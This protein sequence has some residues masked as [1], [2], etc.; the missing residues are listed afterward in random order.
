MNWTQKMLLMGATETITSPAEAAVLDSLIFHADRQTAVS[1]P[2]PKLIAAEARISVDYA[3]EKLKECIKKRY[4]SVAKQGNG[5]GN[6]TEY[7]VHLEIG[8]AV[9]GG[10]SVPPFDEEREGNST[11]LT[12]SKGGYSV[13]ENEP[14]GGT[15]SEDDF[16]K[17][18]TESGPYKDEGYFKRNEVVIMEG[19][20]ES[21]TSAQP[22]PPSPSTERLSSD[23][24]DYAALQQVTGW[25]HGT[26]SRQHQAELVNSLYALRKQINSPPAT[27]ENITRFGELWRQTGKTKPAPGQVVTGWEDIFNPPQKN[28]NERLQNG[29]PAHHLTP[30]QRN[31]AGVREL[32]EREF[33]G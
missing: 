32:L 31:R 18:G 2:G 19:G 3:K 26:R 6:Y 33:S 30:G 8:L 23:E 4:I 17:G 29:R 16:P 5:K 13:G 22:P 10:D 20:V 1:Y 14:K 21:A 12:E 24:P 7:L 28:P 25:Y 9:K 27:P 15:Q 11:P